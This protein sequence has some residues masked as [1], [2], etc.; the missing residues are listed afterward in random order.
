M[1]TFALDSETISRRGTELSEKAVANYRNAI[2]PIYGSTQ[3]GLP[4]HIGT[5]ITLE[6]Y[7][8]KVLL[9]AAHVIDENKYT[10][11]YVGV[12]N[13]I[14]LEMEFYASANKIGDRSDDP[15]D[16]AA[17]KLPSNIIAKL[18]DVTYISAS[19]ICFEENEPEGSIFTFVGYPNSKNKKIDRVQKKAIGSLFQYW[20][21]RAI[22]KSF[23]RKIG[24]SDK[25][26]ILSKFNSKHSR[27]I[28]GRRVNSIMLNGMSGGAVFGLGKLS[29]L[30]ILS[31][32]QTPEPRLVGLIVE[33]HRQEGLV[34]ATR[35]S[36][37]LRALKDILADADLPRTIDDQ[38]AL[39]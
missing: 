20:N 7:S 9:T 5:C 21:T 25:T 33:Y 32:K 31:G 13:L 11:L 10:T 37:I 15:F 36:T 23:M 34:L 26:H 29:D 17:G 28:D 18:D 1:P 8:Q 27:E 38:V 39:P 35:I 16:F 22:D 3:N 19:D 4:E 2:L 24:V 14:P 30:S 12:K 6:V